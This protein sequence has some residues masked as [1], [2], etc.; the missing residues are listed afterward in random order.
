MRLTVGF[1]KGAAAFV[2]GVALTL[3]AFVVCASAQ[4]EA[5]AHPERPGFQAENGATDDGPANRPLRRRPPHVGDLFGRVIHDNMV[6]EALVALT[7]ADES[8]I[9]E[10]L[11]DNDV[12]ELLLN[13][14][15]DLADFKAEMDL[16]AADFLDQAVECGLITGP[17][18]ALILDMLENPPKPPA[19]PDEPPADGETT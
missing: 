13:Y 5:P 19:L 15:I 18:A 4:D 8:V 7:E 9:R 14:E 12:R 10:Q 17:E 6:V 3:A 2:I 1:G 16:L 11:I